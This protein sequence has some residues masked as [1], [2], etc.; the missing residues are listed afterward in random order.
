MVARVKERRNERGGELGFLYRAGCVG[1]SIQYSSESRS[2][3][4]TDNRSVVAVVLSGGT[5]VVLVK[6]ITA[7]T[8]A[9]VQRRIVG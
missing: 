5:S 4:N 3:G 2:V 7:W 9:T 6:I 1:C 8:G